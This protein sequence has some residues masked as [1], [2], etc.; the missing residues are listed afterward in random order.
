MNTTA[1]KAQN[2]LEA[3]LD[4][5]VEEGEK[6][7]S[8]AWLHLVPIGAEWFTEWQANCIAVLSRLVPENN[9]SAHCSHT[10][11]RC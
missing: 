7:L 10:H 2:D 6:K 5:L 3:R 1:G 4:K 8:N 9:S 11:R